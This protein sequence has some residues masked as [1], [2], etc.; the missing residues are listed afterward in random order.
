MPL[1]LEAGE[2]LVNVQTEEDMTL[3]IITIIAR[4]LHVKMA[5]WL[6]AINIMESGVSEKLPAQVFFDLLL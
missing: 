6:I 2:E 3:A 4:A 5:K 1:E